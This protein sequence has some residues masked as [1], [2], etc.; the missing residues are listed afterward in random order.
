MSDA[1]QPLFEIAGMLP[2]D[3]KSYVFSLATHLKKTETDLA[4]VE[5]QLQL[6]EERL[7]LAVNKG[8]AEL[9][10]QAEAKRAELQANRDVLAEEVSQFQ[11]GIAKLKKDLLLL[12]LTQRA[13]NTDQLLDQMAALGGTLDTVT[14]VTKRAEAE[15]ALAALK[16]RI[17]G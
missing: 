17:S 15:D 3:A 5:T 8:M 2:E 9:A 10:T 4:E 11:A 1:N 12:P 7:A 13:V 14:P 16:K 6:W